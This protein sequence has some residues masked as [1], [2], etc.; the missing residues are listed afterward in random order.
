MCFVKPSRNLDD[1]P[2]PHC[3]LCH[4]VAILDRLP[5]PNFIALANH[6]LVRSAE[7]EPPGA[8]RLL[9]PATGLQRSPGL[10][11]RPEATHCLH[12]LSFTLALNEANVG[13]EPAGRQAEAVTLE[14]SV[15][16]A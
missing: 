4:G 15:E 3:P 11:M 12:R 2:T 10:W 9:L 6:H 14:R 13:F 5:R 16:Q 7:V 1:A 8:I